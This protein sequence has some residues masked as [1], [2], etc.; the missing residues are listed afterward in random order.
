MRDFSFSSIWAAGFWHVEIM[1]SG[2]LELDLHVS[3]LPLQKLFGQ[4]ACG[5]D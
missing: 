5:V 3:V 4:K 1:L 2:R